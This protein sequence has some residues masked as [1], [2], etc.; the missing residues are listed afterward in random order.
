MIRGFLRALALAILVLAPALAHADPGIVMEQNPISADVCMRM[1]STVSGGVVTSGGCSRVGTNTAAGFVPT[2]LTTPTS[3]YVTKQGSDAN[4]CLASTQGSGTRGPCLTIPRAI[5][6]A[7][8]F[9][10]VGLWRGISVG[11]GTFD[12]FQ[13]TGAMR[14][15]GG[16][17]ISGTF[18][19]V[20]GAG[21]GQTTVTPVLLSPGNY[22]GFSVELSTHSS[23]VI[24]GMTVPGTIYGALFSQNMAVLQLGDDLALVGSGPSSIA[25]HTEAYGLIEAAANRQIKISGTFGQFYTAGVS[26]YLELDPYGTPGGTITCTGPTSFQQFAYLDNLASMLVGQDW[27]FPGCPANATGSRFSIL[28]NSVIT[29]RSGNPLPGSTPGRVGTGGRSEPYLPATL[30]VINGTTQLFGFGSGASVDVSNTSSYGGI[31][32]VSTGSSPSGAPSLKL[33][34]PEYIVGPSLSGAAPCTATLQDAAGQWSDPATVK[35]TSNYQGTTGLN[36]MGQV[37]G[38]SVGLNGWAVPVNTTLSIAFACQT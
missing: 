11:P 26:G 29:N 34:L 24:G 18:L 4:D 27:S 8:S 1:P 31:V 21:S 37:L 7:Q 2:F 15:A 23:V 30:A 14:G 9:D 17:F 32:T 13:V 20:T 12:G 16:S 33:V 36:Q 35:I 22:Q 25:M 6:A 28:G 3:F 38:F 19:T 5:S 10:A